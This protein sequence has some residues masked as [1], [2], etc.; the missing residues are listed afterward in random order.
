MDFSVFHGMY[1]ER[2]VR[3]AHALVHDPHDAAEIADATFEQLYRGWDRILASG[4][5]TRCAWRVLRNKT[6]DHCRAR[7]RR[8][9]IDAAFDMEAVRQAVDPVRQI[10]ESMALCRALGELPVRQ[11]DVMTLHYFL[12]L[13][14][15]SVADTLGITPAAVRSTARH[16][17]HHLRAILAPGTTVRDPHPHDDNEPFSSQT[18]L[19]PDGNEPLASQ[20]PRTARSTANLAAQ[21]AG[22]TRPHLR[23]EW[24]SLL[25][26]NPEDGVNPSRTQQQLLAAGFLV[27]ALR[28]RLRDVVR[29]AWRPV[30]WLLCAPSRTHAFISATVGVQAIC[31]VRGNGLAALVTDAWE[32]CGI[33]GTAL[34]ALARWLRRVRGIEP[35]TPESDPTEE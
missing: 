31:I 11:R 27:A 9:L 30:D 2:F 22:S 8:P 21:L 13:P 4:N 7:N 33:A 6:M 10:E 24:E 12:G 18:A 26:G 23:D 16:A 25:A 1:R 15:D 35:A 32:P 19:D 14:V 29:P 34:F 28:M 5:P 3:Y 20:V 17:K